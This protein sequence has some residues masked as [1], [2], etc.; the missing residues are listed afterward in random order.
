MLAHPTVRQLYLDQN[1]DGYSDTYKN[2]F[3]KDVGDK[4]YNYRRVYDGVLQD[5][6]DGGWVVK[7]YHDELMPGDKLL[8]RFERNTI[9]HTH[10][11]I[12]WLLE[13]SN[14]DFTHPGDNPVKI[15]R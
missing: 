7:N 2:V 11:V 10:D 5:V 13:T 12:D 15:N 6:A 3:G 9:L 14:W 4:D 1:L 8:D